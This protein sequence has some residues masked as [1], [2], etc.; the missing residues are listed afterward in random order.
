M[1]ETVKNGDFIE[2]EYTGVLKDGN[3]VFDC[4]DADIAKKEE[5]FDPKMSYGPVSICVGQ[6]QI[7]KGLDDAL[8][9]VEIGAEK[10]LEL[11]AEQAFGKKDAK[12]LRLVPT[13]IFKQQGI[14]AVP[15]LQVNIDGN[16]GTIRSVSGGRTVV[17]FNHPFSGKEIVYKV[18]VLRKITDN[19]EKVK[20][21]LH[22]S[23][24]QKMNSIDV[25]IKEGNC[26]ITLKKEF[27]KDLLDFLV[28]RVKKAMPELK[29]V[30]FTVKK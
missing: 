7:L 30:K 29:E 6:A 21:L 14:Q 12:L 5:I 17:D 15:G 26:G 25:E 11:G 20:T 19:V 13:K 3:L 2:L 22:L 18:K 8:E 24:N 23:L 4:T 16:M 27:Q 1:T 10:N 28:E 9:G